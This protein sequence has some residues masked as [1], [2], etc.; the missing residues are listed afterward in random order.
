MKTRPTILFLLILLLL[1]SGLRAEENKEINWQEEIAGLRRELTTRHVD[2]FFN[3]DSTLFYKG[4]DEV[5]KRAPGN[6]VLE[7]G[8]MLQQ[9]VAKLGDANTRVNYNYL[10]DIHLI[11]PFECYWFEEGLYVTDYWKDYASLEGKRMVS[12]NGFPIQEVIDSLSTLISGATPVRIQ[13]E[14]TKMITWV[15]VLNYFGFASE[16]EVEIGLEDA[17]GLLSKELIR[18]PSPESE[19]ISITNRSG[20]GSSR[21]T[22]RDVT[23]GTWFALHG[24]RDRSRTIHFGAR[25]NIFNRIYCNGTC[26]VRGTRGCRNNSQSE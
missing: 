18:L 21:R 13:Y 6:S 22:A 25:C 11:L 3:A 1:G 19:R 2:L 17:S 9:E 24:S 20:M 16:A 7:V 8:M 23:D 26:E 12:I 5:V 14:V 15:Q 4:L 10:I